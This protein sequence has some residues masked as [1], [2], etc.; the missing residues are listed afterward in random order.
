MIKKIYFLIVAMMI[1]I[2]PNSVKASTIYGEKK[3]PVIS[4][5]YKAGFYS[6]DN[7]TNVDI[8]VMLLNDTP[9][10]VMILDNEMNIELLMKLPYNYK[11][12]LRNIG[13]DKTIGIVGEG[14]VAIIFE[15]SK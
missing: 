13:P 9:T 10:K 2:L 15:S 4:D 7:K 5:T 3:I 1:I 11:F 8:G 6:F 14:D 12:H